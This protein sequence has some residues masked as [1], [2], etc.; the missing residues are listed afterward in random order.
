M[1]SFRGA[2]PPDMDKLLFA[3]DL[4]SHFINKL[5]YKNYPFGSINTA[6]RS[7]G[8]RR[9]VHNGFDENVR[10][11]VDILYKSLRRKADQHFMEISQRNGISSSSFDEFETLLRERYFLDREDAKDFFRYCVLMAIMT[12]HFFKWNNLDMPDRA[13]DF[14][15][16]RFPEGEMSE[17]SWD[18]LNRVARRIARDRENDSESSSSSDSDPSPDSNSQ[19]E[20]KCNCFKSEIRGSHFHVVYMM[21]NHTIEQH[22]FKCLSR[23]SKQEKSLRLLPEPSTLESLTDNEKMS[24]KKVSIHTK[25][26]TGS[27]KSYSECEL[28]DFSGLTLPKNSA[29]GRSAIGDQ[30][31]STSQFPDASYQN[32]LKSYTRRLIS[33]SQPLRLS[34][35]M[36]HKFA[37]ERYIDLTYKRQTSPSEI[38]HGDFEQPR[39]VDGSLQTDYCQP[40]TSQQLDASWD[41]L[42]P[43]YK[44]GKLSNQQN[45]PPGISSNRQCTSEPATYD[46]QD[47]RSHRLTFL[48]LEMQGFLAS[49]NISKANQ[50]A[51]AV[52][53]VQETVGIKYELPDINYEHLLATQASG[54]TK[55]TFKSISF[56]T[57]SEVGSGH[58]MIQS[59]RG[60]GHS[61]EGNVPISDD[62]GTAPALAV[63]VTSN[64]EGS[65]V[66]VADEFIPLNP[67]ENRDNSP[68]PSPKKLKML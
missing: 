46:L 66:P 35:E 51:H 53:E 43:F 20:S 3:E 9:Y 24:S 58:H 41:N 63:Q 21:R 11:A 27:E 22:N 64:Q 67:K 10:K 49:G 54:D 7:E 31:S 37:F 16:K 25:V 65:N 40:S 15:V 39:T 29:E 62:F 8:Y 14:I 55:K 47:Q 61:N 28:P 48:R 60:D 34:P 42:L 52:N 45:D 13:C 44:G 38:K 50:W 68:P 23:T 2:V 6:P 36:I 56:E 17:V 4:I 18:L 59:E 5:V 33:E 26:Q 19:N 1:A 57:S 32:L 30:Q 12:K